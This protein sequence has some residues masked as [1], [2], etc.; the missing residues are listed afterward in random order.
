MILLAVIFCSTSC[1]A[2][3]K[4]PETKIAGFIDQTVS[5]VGYNNGNKNWKTYCTGVW[6]DEFTILTANHCAVA[7]KIMSLPSEERLFASMAGKDLDVI[8]APVYYSVK[9]SFNNVLTNG[10]LEYMKAEVI[11]NNKDNDLAMITT[12]D[13]PPDHKSATLANFSPDVGEEIFVMGHPAG[14]EFT[15]THGYVSAY[16]SGID[17]EALDVKGPFMQMNAVI[18]GGNSGGGVFDLKGNLCGIVSFGVRSAPGNGFAIPVGPIEIFINK[19]K[20][21]N[22]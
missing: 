8:G 19:N 3:A 12:L 15:Y 6:I 16:R 20:N 11:A 1:Y 18:S 7:A 5:L 2:P 21:R 14:I 17:P 4:M 22:K 13:L 9:K 10:P